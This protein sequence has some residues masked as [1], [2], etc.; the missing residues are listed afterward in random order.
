MKKI[1]PGERL[2]HFFFMPSGA[3][4]LAFFRMSIALLG[5]V[6]LYWLRH[7]IL[8]LYGENGLVRWIITENVIGKEALRLGWL[9]SL[10]AKAGMSSDATVYSLIIVYALSLVGM[11][12]GIFTR[13][14]AII[15][16]LLHYTLTN[17]AFMSAYGV[18]S[19]LHIALFYCAVMPVSA[20]FSPAAART[21]PSWN[22]WNTLSLRVLQLHLCLVYMS[23][24]LEKSMGVQWWNGE[25]IWRSVMQM[26]YGQYEMSWLANWPWVAK[27]ACWGTLLLEIAYPV[28]IWTRWRGWWLSGIV[29]MHLGIAVMLGLQL[30]AAIMIL[31]NLSAFGWPYLLRYWQM[32]SGIKRERLRYRLR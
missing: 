12:S 23:T 4:P 19:F 25:A 21:E 11:L 17:T 2:A 9:S 7:D 30:F 28:M 3:A 16:L 8:L 24:G 32:F 20:A 14:W 10:T 18:E 13:G 15:A 27:I 26:Q 6:Q 29:L 5:L 31:F 1:N 22:G